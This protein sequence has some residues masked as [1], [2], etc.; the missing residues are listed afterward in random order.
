MESSLKISDSLSS[1]PSSF[2]SLR[3]DR[4]ICVSF[5]ARFHLTRSARSLVCSGEYFHED[6]LVHVCSMP[7]NEQRVAGWICCWCFRSSAPALHENATSLSLSLD[8]QVL[9]D[10]PLALQ[11]PPHERADD[12]R[13]AKSANS[14][15]CLK[16]LE[17]LSQASLISYSSVS[18]RTVLAKGWFRCHG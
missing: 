13:S 2:I 10:I 11:P 3:A 14:W 4:S 9:G 1:K 12:V 8:L 16:C 18:Y 6:P 17:A 7:P 5:A 15:S